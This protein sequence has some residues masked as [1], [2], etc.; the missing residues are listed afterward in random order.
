MN[1]FVKSRGHTNVANVVNL[2]ENKTT[3]AKTNFKCLQRIN[4]YNASPISEL[5]SK[6]RIFITRES[7]KYATSGKGIK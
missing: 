3:W 5:C 6:D 7:P 4:A 1:Y 2:Q